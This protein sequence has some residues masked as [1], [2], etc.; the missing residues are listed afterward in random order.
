[1]SHRSDR[2]K[3]TKIKHFFVFDGRS[4]IVIHST[5]KQKYDCATDKTKKRRFGEGERL[6]GKG[7][8]VPSFWES[9]SWEGVKI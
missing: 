7:D 9:L 2:Q 4:T 5:I 1:M 8:M 3:V 6:W